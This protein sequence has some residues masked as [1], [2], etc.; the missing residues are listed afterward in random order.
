MDETRTA[1]P[2]VLLPIV[3]AAALLAFVVVGVVNHDGGIDAAPLLR[4]GGALLVTW[5]GLAPW[6]GVY[7]IPG[8]RTLLVA[9]GVGVPLGVV[10]RSAAAGGPW[11]GRLLVFLGVAMAFSLL[12]LLAGRL[13]ARALA[14][15]AG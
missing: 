13:L 12:F 5:F 6:T 14:R 4:T 8:L 11:N 10:L 3:D 9:W 15:T 1:R 2:T 7:R